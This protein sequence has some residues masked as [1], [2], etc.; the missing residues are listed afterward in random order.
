MNKIK[1]VDGRLV[2][3]TLT[4]SA[5]VSDEPCVLT[6]TKVLRCGGYA[7][8]VNG[9]R[10]VRDNHHLGGESVRRQAIRLASARFSDIM[11]PLGRKCD[12]QSE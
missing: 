9:V 12:G 5:D 7:Y 1:R 2:Q 8:V 10:R 6:V 4:F 3:G 11:N